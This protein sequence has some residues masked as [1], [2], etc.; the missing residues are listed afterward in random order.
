MKPREVMSGLAL[1]LFLILATPSEL[2]AQEDAETIAAFHSELA[3]RVRALPG[4]SEAATVD[5]LPLNH[6]SSG[7]E[8]EI[9]GEQ[10]DGVENDCRAFVFGIGLEE[11]AVDLER[12]EWQ[13]R[14]VGQG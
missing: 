4:V 8:F 11:H 5:Y 6:E 3:D 12:V 9:V 2:Q 7:A 13:P 14:Q 10:D 1:L